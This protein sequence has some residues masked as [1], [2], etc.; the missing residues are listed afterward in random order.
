MKTVIVISPAPNMWLF[1]LCVFASHAL[2]APAS[3]TMQQAGWDENDILRA[4]FPANTLC[5]VTS[6]YT[7]LREFGIDTSYESVLTKMPP[8]IYG[9]TMRQIVDYFRDNG[10]LDVRAFRCSAAE[11]YG[12]LHGAGGLRALINMDEHWV[13]VRNATGEAFEIVDFPRKYF[14]PVEAVDNLWEGYAVIISRKSSPLTARAVLLGVLLVCA[15]AAPVALYM[16]IS[17]T[18]ASR[19]VG[20]AKIHG[21]LS[22]RGCRNSRKRSGRRR[23]RRTP[24]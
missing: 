17:A 7:V 8:G 3:Q 13:V 1:L 19:S 22:R 4:G 6:V 12:R 24:P 9:N 11:L 10:T 20:R 5:G 2:T 21:Q 16:L 14:I 23:G 18:S 15:A